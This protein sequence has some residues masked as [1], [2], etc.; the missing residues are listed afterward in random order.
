MP[1]LRFIDTAAG[2]V[3]YAQGGRGADVVL[4]HGAMTSVEDM[5]LGPFEALAA[6]FRVTAFDRPGHGATPR[7][8]LDGAPSR[9]TSQILAA[10]TALGIERP[11]VIG[12]SFG[13]A[14]AMALA[15]EAPQRVQGVL[16]ISPLA[17][18]EWRLEHF[19]YGP[20]AVVGMGELIGHGPGRLLD[21]LLL[22]PLWHAIFAPQPMPA[23]FAHSF[24]FALASGPSQMAAV[25]EEALLSIPDLA[26]AALRYPSCQVA[27]SVL[28]G[29]AD[30]LGPPWTHAA[31]LA[32]AIPRARLRLLPGLGHMLHHFAQA[33]I[34]EEAD[35]LIG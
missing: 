7:R 30:W 24:P 26:L 19:L 16:A 12:Q 35:E 20:R 13:A 9:Q 31:A 25:G 33:R 18:P 17:F 23:R 27:V 15:L 34:V 22:P 8:R 5:L 1:P 14:L 29:T 2:P 6:R 10:M 21:A 4:L 32:A 3:R 11:V 28:S